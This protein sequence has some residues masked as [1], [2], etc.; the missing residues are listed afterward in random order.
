M[1]IWWYFSTHI[2]WNPISSNIRRAQI[3]LKQSNI[4]DWVG[5]M[6]ATSWKKGISQ[7]WEIPFY[8]IYIYIYI[9]D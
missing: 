8:T 7:E 5:F 3:R 6:E 4:I 9:Y 1:G 2:G